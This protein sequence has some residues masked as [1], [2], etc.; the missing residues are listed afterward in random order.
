MRRLMVK[1]F[2]IMSLY[3][4]FDD[5]KPKDPKYDY[6]EAVADLKGKYS[7]F[8]REKIPEM[9]ADIKLFRRIKC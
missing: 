5:K 4:T 9:L 7:A 6:D 2:D 8:A 3:I 1:F